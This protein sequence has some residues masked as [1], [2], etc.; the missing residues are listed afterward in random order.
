MQETARNS[1]SAGNSEETAG[2][3]AEMEELRTGENT[4]G[5]R[6]RQAEIIRRRVGS[7][8]FRSRCPYYSWKTKKNWYVTDY[9]KDGDRYYAGEQRGAGRAANEGVHRGQ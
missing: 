2:E 8:N 9:I 7:R 6:T 4:R 1:E 5:V 3:N